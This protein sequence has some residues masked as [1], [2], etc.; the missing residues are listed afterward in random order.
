MQRERDGFNFPNNME[1]R[2]NNETLNKKWI[3][4]NIKWIWYW[5]HFKTVF[6]KTKKNKLKIKIEI[7]LYIKYDTI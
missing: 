4:I 7:I 6:L 5:F 2:C 3:D 1:K